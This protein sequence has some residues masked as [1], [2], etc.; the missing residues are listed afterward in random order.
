MLPPM[1]EGRKHYISSG[2]HVTCN[3]NCWCKLETTQKFVELIFI[4]YKGVQVEKLALLEDQKMVW[5]IERW[6]IHKSKLFLDQMKL[7]FLGICVI[8]ILANCTSILL[9]LVDV[10]LKC[11]FKCMHSCVRISFQDMFKNQKLKE[12]KIL[13]LVFICQFQNQTY[14][15]GFCMHGFM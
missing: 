15:H 2:F 3:F 8:F 6:S 7:Q 4:L 5:L 1:N 9:E 13:K 10:I 11:L 14:V 12:M